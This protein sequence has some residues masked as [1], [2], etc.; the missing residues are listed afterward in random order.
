MPATTRLVSRYGGIRLYVPEKLAD[1]HELIEVLGRTAAIKLVKTFALEQLWIPRCQ[2]AIC[3]A[4]DAE[5]RARHAD[6][7]KVDA[8]AR[9]YGLTDRWVWAIVAATGPDS[10]QLN[11]L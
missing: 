1:D 8:L 3:A 6:G 2:A 4:R 5:I 10:L 7:E 11:L 9:E